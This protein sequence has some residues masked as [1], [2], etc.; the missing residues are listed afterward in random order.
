M[1]LVVSRA[2]VCIP[3][4]AVDFVSLAEIVVLAIATPDYDPSTSGDCERHGR[5]RYPTN[6]LPAYW[7]IELSALRIVLQTEGTWLHL[8]VCGCN[9]C[10]CLLLPSVI[11]P[12][13]P[14]TDNCEERDEGENPG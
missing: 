12:E 1:C 9:P 4:G 2:I 7:K 3:A 11:R 5:R 10:A 8:P 14:Q 6:P 13:N